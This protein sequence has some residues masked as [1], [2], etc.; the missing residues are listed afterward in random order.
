MSKRLFLA[1]NVFI[2]AYVDALLS[3]RFTWKS[4]IR[5]R[6]EPWRPACSR[7]HTHMNKWRHFVGA[8]ILVAGLAIKLGAPLEAVAAG[9][10]LCGITIWKFEHQ[11]RRS[12]R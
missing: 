1:T 6:T 9:I 7:C 11:T 3:W 2:R 10:V 4:Q 5:R 8:S 12:L